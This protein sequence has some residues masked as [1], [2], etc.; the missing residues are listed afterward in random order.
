MHQLRGDVLFGREI[1]EERAGSDSGGAGEVA[2]G[3]LLETRLEE[4]AST[5]LEY[6]LAGLLLGGGGDS[7]ERSFFMNMLTLYADLR[8]HATLK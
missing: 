2:S 3:R 6:T 5:C 8:S 1:V 4:Q 7:H